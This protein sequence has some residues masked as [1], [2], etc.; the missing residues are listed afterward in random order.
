MK[1]KENNE[2]TQILLYSC[3]NFCNYHLF[4]SVSVLLLALLMI[5]N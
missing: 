5:Y 3:Q 4:N 1:T 2:C